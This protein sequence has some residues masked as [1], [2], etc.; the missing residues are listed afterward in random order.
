MVHDAKR[1]GGQRDARRAWIL[2]VESL[3]GGTGAGAWLRRSW[4][5]AIATAA[6]SAL[7]LQAKSAGT[8]ACPG[9]HC[10]HRVSSGREATICARSVAAP[11]RLVS[12]VRPSDYGWPQVCTP[13]AASRYRL[14]PVL[15]AVTACKR[16]AAARSCH[17][18][19]GTG[20]ASTLKRLMD[21]TPHEAL[22]HVAT[23]I[24]RGSNQPA[25]AAAC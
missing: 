22:R 17:A 11:P 5:A 7:G 24:R 13:E 14:G 21:V 15:T 2:S 25:S 10:Q 1:T 18:D 23:S 12:S 9:V 16:K 8:V 6:I 3:G 4:V 20:T 19:L